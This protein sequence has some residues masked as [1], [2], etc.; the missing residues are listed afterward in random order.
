MKKVLHRHVRQLPL[1]LRLSLLLVFMFPVFIAQAQE[2][3]ISGKVV[4]G[5]QPVPGVTVKVK[6]TNQGAVTDINGH[7]T[8]TAKQGDT[9]V[10]NHM[11]YA[12]QSIAVAGPSVN[13][14]LSENSQTVGEVVVVGYGTQKKET[15]TGSISVVKGADIVRSPQPNVSNSLAG[16]FSGVIANNRAGEPGYD[17]SNIYI[18]GLGTTGNN[19]VLVVV[20]GVPGQIGGLSRLDPN[21]IESISVLK[22]ASAAVYGSRAANG[23]IL[24]TTK[25]GK[26]GKPV[27]N[28]TFNQ[29][30]SSP[31]R[32]PKMADAPTFAAIQN[33][34]AYYTDPAGGMNQYYTDEEIQKYRD[35][36]D[37]LNYPNT[38]WQKVVLKK[39]AT[40][41]QHNLAVSGGTTDVRYYASLGTI[42]QDGLYKNGATKYN[43]YNFRSNIDADV[44]KR[45]KVSLYL[46][47]REEDRNYPVTSAGDIFRAIYRAYPTIAPYYP[48]GLPTYGI[49]GSNPALIGTSIGGTS[50]N[51]TQVFN[52]ILKGAYQIPGVE[53]LSLDGFYSIDKSWSFI[54]TFSKPYSVYNYNSTTGAYDK[55]IVGGSNGLATLSEGQLNRTMMVSNI[56]LNYAHQFGK[57]NIAAFV[58]YEQSKTS[59]DS[60]GA[61][62][63]NFPSS[64]TPELSQGGP[65]SED[66]NNSGNSYNFTRKSYFGKLAYNYQEKYLVE[67]QARVDG[68]SAFPSGHQYGFFPSISAGYRISQEPWF[69]GVKFINDLKL[70]GSYGSLGNDNISLFQYFDNYS[71][72]SQYVIGDAVHAGIDLTKLANQN[73]TWEVAKKL[74]VGLNAIFLD[75]F[76]VEFI[77]FQQKRSDILTQR[78]ASI[79]GTSGIVNPYG[80]DPL[81]P[82]ENIGKVNSNGIEATLGYNNVTK[83]G[84]RYGINT[85][86]TYAKS[87]IIYIDEAS[88][89]LDYQRQTGHPMN[90]SLLYNAIGIFRT[91]EDLDKYPHLANA[92][93]GDLIYQDYNNDGEITADDQTRTK[94]G[95]IPEITYGI[96]LNGA[97]KGFDASVVFAGQ[98]HVSQYVLPESGT[99]GNF[100]SSWADNRW[101]PTHTDGTYPRVDTRASSSVNGGLYANNFWLNNASFLRLKNVELGYTINATL[102]NRAKISSL[103]VYASAYNLFTIT[104]VK[105]Y[106][107]EGNSSSGQFYPQQRIVNL[108]LNVKF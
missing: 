46:S 73:I 91:Q 99:I 10:F 76:N 95:N 21:D 43:Q 40:Q 84:F 16:R 34:I 92:Q 56:K 80:S 51:P 61:Y 55:T 6:G 41:Q 87:K 57:H 39:S 79:P 63:M 47:G 35:G 101:S 23:V 11:S 13:A 7:Y 30:F 68:S 22:D 36:S 2:G 62:R 66:K 97:Y 25:R 29:G 5:G 81:V 67:A 50:R 52:G 3:K 108:G 37:P 48:N 83:G 74:D 9:L 69:K 72:N 20:D 89:T 86:I 53:G 75:H 106:D 96:L 44:T 100:Y 60:L 65:A 85:N 28:Y 78:N 31:T 104:K 12:A 105:D 90:T 27:I 49:E 24:V 26:T 38:D 70:R 33:E 45:L 71:F 14:T 42:S 19:D 15:L 102:L 103:R 32:L 82:A 93:L 98:T 17:N 59:Q 1:F 94:Y 8:V 18:R 77:Y 107:P 58:A 64:T 54:K 88:G 4:S